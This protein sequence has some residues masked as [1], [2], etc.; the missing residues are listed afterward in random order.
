[1][2]FKLLTTTI[3]LTVMQQYS[4]AQNATPQA[5]SL[6]EAQD[7][8]LKNSVTLANS[9]IDAQ[10]A[11]TKVKET[12]G[13]GLPQVSGSF[14][15]KHFI[16]IPTSLLPAQVFGG[17]PGEFIGVK[18]GTANNATLGLSVSQLLFSSDYLIG[19]QATKAYL[20]LTQKSAG[21]SNNDIKTNVA[22]AYFNVLVSKQRAE[23]LT[24][25][26]DQIAKLRNDTKAFNTQ[27]FVELIDV[28]RIEVLYNNLVT[29]KQKIDKLLALGETLLKFQMNFDAKQAI[30][31][32]DKIE[33]Q[34]DLNAMPAADAKLDFSNR[35]EYA[36]LQTNLKLNEL[37]LKRNKLSF[38][39][40]VVAYGA[41]Q[42]NAQRTKFDIFKPNLPWYQTNLIGATINLPIFNGFQNHF[43]RQQA[44][45][46]VMK[47]KNNMRSLE[48]GI[49]LETQASLTSYENAVSSL[50]NQKRNIALAQNIY[51]VSK[52]KYDQGVGSNLEILNAATSLKE[53]ETNYSIALY[54]YYIAKIDY[55]KATGTIK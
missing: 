19:V 22:K 8:A 28:D 4:T 38:L 40:T 10:I 49:A 13:I 41:F 11:E 35:P 9:A 55:E 24:T 54:D 1:M 15:V 51:N 21:I 26:I 7:Y 33:E 29:E 23:L 30:T 45:L 25:N 12:I 43:K 44:M 36:L 2:N 47:T 3:A 27:G 39:P 14:D 37:D 53:A 17:P 34:V 20:E 52:K 5:F 6:K 16:T 46:N 31:L 32:T 18:F 42:G 50:S 48:N